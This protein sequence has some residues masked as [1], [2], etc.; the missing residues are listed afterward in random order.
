M[1]AVVYGQKGTS[2]R[3]QCCQDL[4]FNQYCTSVLSSVLI[5]F[6]D[7]FVTGLTALKIAAGLRGPQRMNLKNIGLFQS[8]T[9]QIRSKSYS[10]H[11]F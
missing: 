7:Y 5:I 4:A 2:S 11:M 1:L 8:G 9:D 6:F 10:Y 3:A